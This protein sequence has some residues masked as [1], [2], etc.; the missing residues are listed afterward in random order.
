MR[1]ATMGWW[2][3]SLRTLNQ[4]GPATADPQIPMSGF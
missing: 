4:T 1:P 2:P 3:S